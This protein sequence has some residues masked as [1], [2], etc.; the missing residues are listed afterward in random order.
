[1]AQ[2]HAVDTWPFRPY[3]RLYLGMRLRS[4]R[5]LYCTVRYYGASHPTPDLSNKNLVY[6]SSRQALADVVT[7]KAVIQSKYN[8]TDKIKWISFG[9][10]YSGALSAWLRLKYPGV[11]HG[12]VATSAPVL[13][14]F[15]F[16]EYLE[17][18]ERSLWSSSAG[19]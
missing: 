7:L 14:K 2:A 4:L 10:S 19:M 9:G 11:V 17:V 12:A 18:V 5:H 15:N 1:M 6:L 13:A 3:E 16:Y 8:L